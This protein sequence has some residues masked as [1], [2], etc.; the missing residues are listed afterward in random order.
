MADTEK[1]FGYATR[2]DGAV[3]RV[4]ADVPVGEKPYNHIAPLIPTGFRLQ[5]YGPVDEDKN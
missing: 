1:W 3:K 4:F 5:G 2:K